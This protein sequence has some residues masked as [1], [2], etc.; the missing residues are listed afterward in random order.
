MWLPAR[1]RG[2]ELSGQSTLAVLTGSRKLALLTNVLV[3]FVMHALSL[4][5]CVYNI[6]Y[7]VL[8]VL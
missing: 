5:L 3:S 1:W 6:P 4:R 7:V 8:E 2:S